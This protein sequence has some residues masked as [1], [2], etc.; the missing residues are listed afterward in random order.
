MSVHAVVTHLKCTWQ[1]AE[2]PHSSFTLPWASLQFASF[3]L[4][5][6]GSFKIKWRQIW[7]NEWAVP[8]FQRS[9]DWWEAHLLK[10]FTWQK[11]SQV[12]KLRIV[13]EANI[14]LKLNWSSPW[15][16]FSFNLWKTTE[17]VGGSRLIPDDAGDCQRCPQCLCWLSSQA[18]KMTSSA[19]VWSL[20]SVHT[21]IFSFLWM[22]EGPNNEQQDQWKLGASSSLLTQSQDCWKPL[23][24]DCSTMIFD[25]SDVDAFNGFFSERVRHHSISVNLWDGVGAFGKIFQWSND[26]KLFSN[27]AVMMSSSLILFEII[28]INER[29][30]SQSICRLTMIG[31]DR[32]VPLWNTTLLGNDL[33]LLFVQTLALH[34]EQMLEC[35]Q[36]LCL[37]LSCLWLRCLPNE[38]TPWSCH[39]LFLKWHW[40]VG[41]SSCKEHLWLLIDQ[42]LLKSTF[43]HSNPQS[44]MWFKQASGEKQMKCLWVPKRILFLWLASAPRGWSKRQWCCVRWLWSCWR[45]GCSLSEVQFHQT[46]V[47]SKETKVSLWADS[48][49]TAGV[50]V[51]GLVIDT[52][53]WLI[54][55]I[56]CCLPLTVLC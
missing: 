1:E 3:E 22:K 18:M 19:C 30:F 7:W 11:V 48:H 8:W 4:H 23:G 37:L 45:L 29:F 35:D 34:V 32:S 9:A 46:A 50:K 6:H 43:L 51:H 17:F 42:L 56:M 5:D 20:H 2:T 24:L 33:C 31:V 36:L 40:I 49:S 44:W 47:C 14:N 26:D 39:A 52:M 25:S 41:S 12:S 53:N 13:S 38:V 27:V 10:C 15:L 16:K 21:A 28:L 55:S 54:V